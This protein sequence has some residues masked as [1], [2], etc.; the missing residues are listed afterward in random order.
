MSNQH[1]P[2]SPPFIGSPASRTG[3]T[4][5]P[6]EHRPDAAIGSV[7]WPARPHR[8]EGRFRCLHCLWVHSSA[9]RAIATSLPAG[10]SNS[11]HA[12]ESY[13]NH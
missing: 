1:D 2:A 12:N 3:A 4:T 8:Q 13:I 10:R 7:A 5:S 11:S 9:S 6:T